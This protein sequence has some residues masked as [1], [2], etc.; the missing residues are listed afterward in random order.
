MLSS[1]LILLVALSLTYGQSNETIVRQS[2]PLS[3][4]SFNEII[5]DGA[6]DVSLKQLTSNDLSDNK[7]LPSVEIETTVDAQQKIIVEIV[8]GHILSI[9]ARSVVVV[10]NNIHVYIQFVTPLHRYTIKGIGNT[11]S[12]ENGLSNP[13]NDI[14]VLD[15][16][17]TANVALQLDFEEFEASLS[18]TGNSRLW[19]RIR[20][21]ATI[22]V[23][24]V[25]DV[26]ALNL[27]TKRVFV[28]SSGVSTVRVSATDDV[29]IEV[30]GISTVHY[31]LPPGKTPSKTISTG[32]G[33][34]IRIS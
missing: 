3:S 1:I 16:R 4:S 8:D 17:G 30:T 31:R 27:V 25:G 22:E 7:L 9:N 32:L 28:E 23:K 13:R 6:F 10:P 15:N 12:D 18:G 2:R 5:V 19:G 20:D 34:I 21:K 11:V 14:F 24:G 33:K 26:N 29:Q